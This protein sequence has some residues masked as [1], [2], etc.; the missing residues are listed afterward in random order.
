MLRMK[1]TKLNE[2]I[3]EDKVVK[4]QWELAPGHEVQYRAEG[5]DEEIKLK[6]SLIAA[7]PDA[8]VIS[9]TDRQSDQEI[10]TS[11]VK[12]SGRWKL[13]AKN[14]V[15]FEVEKESGKNDVLA[16]KEAWKVNDAH[17]IVY[18]YE[19]Q[20]LKTKKKETR[21]LIFKGH[22]DI[23][24]RNRLTY[25]LGG[26]SASVFRIRG[27]FQTKSILAKK[28]EIRYQA[29]M[30]IAGRRKIQTIVLFG[31]WVVSRDLNLSFEIE[32]SGR[33][34]KAILLGGEYNLDGSR[35]IAVNLK[36][37]EGKSLGIELI[38]TKDIFGKDGRAFVRLEKSIEE[39]RGEAGMRFR[40]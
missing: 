19:T 24:E 13:D 21:E 11:L 12:L 10:V 9:V 5:K 26:D 4:G 27:A 40:W 36:S 6:G 25:T 2:L 30:E 14:R 29:G 22:W 34:K 33:K 28:G 15:T 8:L 31:K 39:S 23:S 7:E 38:L 1:L 32:Y 17:E 18:R 35:Q 20:K 37:R 16:F 3:E